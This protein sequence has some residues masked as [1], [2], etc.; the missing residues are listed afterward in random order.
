M[1][2]RES[3]IKR[4]NP[5]GKLRWV[6]R[7]TNAAGERKHAG[8]FDRKGEAQEAIDAAHR[9]EE[10]STPAAEMT[11]GEFYETWPDRYPRTKQ[12]AKSHTSRLKAALAIPVDGRP[13]REHVYRQLERRH[14]VTAID[15]MLRVEGRAAKGAVGLRNSL[16]AM[17][18]D[19]I[20]DGVATVNFAKGA[21]IRANDPRVRKAP[22]EIRVWTF[23]QLRA[24]AAAGRPEVRRET[25]RPERHRQTGEALHYSAVDYEP[26]L[27]TLCLANFRIGEVF[28][29]LRSELDLKEGMFYPT[30]TAYNGEIIRGNT[31]E[32]RHEG[33]NPIAPSLAAIL[34]RMVP[35]IDTL[36]LFPTPS[37]GVW[38]D[39]NFRRDVWEPAQIASGL[40]IRPHEARHSY[41]SHLRAADI[42]PA[43]LAEVT[44]HTLQTATAHYTH[45]TRQSYDEIRRAIG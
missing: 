39:K 20:T 14:M 31:R 29:L 13:L 44:R 28:A 7:Y 22:K 5:S 41:V 45:P 38:W 11:I 8:T 24:F 33:A 1:K 40:D 37:G 3:P 42:D 18:E 32:K 23:D 26:V 4:T 30:G 9:S 34:E 43:D 16:S 17:T 25:P 15:Y 12:T 6:A 2:R 36:L 19:A 21:K 10:A 27:A 35:R